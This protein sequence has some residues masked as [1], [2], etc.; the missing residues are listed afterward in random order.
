MKSL[1]PFVFSTLIVLCFQNCG[2]G[3]DVRNASNRANFL[4]DPQFIPYIQEFEYFH[5]S[6]VSHVPIGFADLGEKIAGVCYRTVIDGKILYSYIEINREYWPTISELQ[7][8]NLIF[9]ELGHCA[10]N[11]DHVESDSVR[12]CPISFMHYQIM[13]TDCLFNNYDLYLEE[14]FPNGR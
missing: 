3:F 6:S 7:K 12:I 10:L 11:R 1:I 9:H 13:S 2:T 14:M 4:T 5:G 8:I